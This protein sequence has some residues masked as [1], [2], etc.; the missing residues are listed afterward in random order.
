MVQT[1]LLLAVNWERTKVDGCR[2]LET[3]DQTMI[4]PTSP[5]CAVADGIA[6]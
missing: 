5:S 3:M 2:Q 4:S 1:P 6:G